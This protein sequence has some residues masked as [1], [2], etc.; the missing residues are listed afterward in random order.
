MATGF[1]YE[2]V[3]IKTGLRYIGKHRGTIDDG[4]IAS[5]KILVDEFNKRPEDFIRSILWESLETNDSEL[6][7]IESTY[8]S[9]IGNDEFYLRKNCKFYN[10]LNNGADAYT[11]SIAKHGKDGDSKIKS[12]RMKGNTFGKGN[13]GKI[14]SSEH[15]KNISIN[16]K[17]GRPAVDVIETMQ[18]Y[19]QHGLKC[20]AK[21]LGISYDAFKARVLLAKKQLTTSE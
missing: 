2:W 6:C 8:L 4:Y 1:I 17:G 21:E 12:D 11:N 16:H 19:K 3:D 9:K 7:K 18:I 10:Q 20:G 14:K 15:K 5:S 13:A